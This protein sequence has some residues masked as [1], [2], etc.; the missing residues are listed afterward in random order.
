MILFDYLLIAIAGLSM[1]LSL[2]RGFVREIISLIGLVAAFFAASRA[3]GIVANLVHDWIPNT[4]VANIAGFTL[5]FVAVMVVVALVGALIRKLVDMADLT[6]TDRT[7][8]MFFGLARGLL[9]IGLFF[10]IYTSY[11]KPD[12]P[13]M[14]KSMLTPYAIEMGNMLGKAIPE[15]YPFSRQGSG[16]PNVPAI[17][18]LDKD[19]EAVKSIIRKS[20]Q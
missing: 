11:A 20:M 14:K 9:L 13:W 19:K 1:V 18:I 10:L 3:S 2:W 17:N 8:G 6:A 16:K 12:K 5:V 7:L 4:T 15:G